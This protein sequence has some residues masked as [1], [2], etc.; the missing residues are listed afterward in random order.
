MK[1]SFHDEISPSI[2]VAIALHQLGSVYCARGNI[3]KSEEYLIKSL[4]MQ[5]SFHGESSPGVA[6]TYQKRGNLQ[7]AEEQLTVTR[8]HTT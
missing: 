5:K 2:H 8:H 7:K 3:Q 1:K 6:V 4:E